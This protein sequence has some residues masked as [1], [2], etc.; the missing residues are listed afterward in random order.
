MKTVTVQNWFPYVQ[1]AVFPSRLFK[2]FF[3]FNFKLFETCIT[4]Q[5]KKNSIKN[6]IPCKL[7]PKRQC[8]NCGIS[9]IQPTEDPLKFTCLRQCGHIICLKCVNLHCAQVLDTL[10]TFVALQYFERDTTHINVIGFFFKYIV[11]V[12]LLSNKK[13]QLKTFEDLM[14]KSQ[15]NVKPEASKNVNALSTEKLQEETT[16]TDTTQNSTVEEP[17]EKQRKTKKRRN[18]KIVL[19]QEYSLSDLDFLL[20]YYYY[21]LK[22]KGLSQIGKLLK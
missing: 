1:H 15:E 16:S 7:H 2:P 13:A 14:Q 11:Y 6:M 9:T 4:Y 21:F 8:Y 19:K 22:L 5:K 3:Q 12:L 20:T 17:S 10:L 18:P